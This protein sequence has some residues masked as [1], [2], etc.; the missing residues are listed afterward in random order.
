MVQEETTKEME[1]ENGFEKE[2]GRI[3]SLKRG[4][5]ESFNSLHSKS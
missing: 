5:F 4:R 2:E 3:I 1:A